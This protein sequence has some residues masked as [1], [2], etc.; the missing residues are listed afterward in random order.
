MEWIKSR[1]Q[2]IETGYNWDSKFFIDLHVGQAM[3]GHLEV[4][5]QFCTENIMKYPSK[6]IVNEFICKRMVKC[7]VKD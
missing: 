7:N 4:E 3:L 6:E 5:I 1:H 2:G